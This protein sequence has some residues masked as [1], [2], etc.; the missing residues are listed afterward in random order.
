MR[1]AD[2]DV[3][4]HRLRQARA[5]AFPPGEFVGQESFVSAGEVLMLGR[6]AGIAPGVRVLDL[7]CGEGGPGLHLAREL[8]C[9]HLGVDASARS[10]AHARARADGEGVT[11]RFEVARVPP[12]PA[13][14][15]DV[16]LL[17]E[18]LLA[19]P[20][21]RAL[22]AEV[23]AALVPGG[24]FAFTLEEGRPLTPTEAGSMP[25][26]GTVWLTPL[27]RLRADLNRAGLRVRWCT[28]TSRAHRVTVDAL[29]DAYA[30]AAPDLRAAG[31]GP[32]VDDL[33][34]SH[35]LWSRWLRE[36]RVRKFAVVA[37]KVRPWVS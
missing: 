36:G 17:L 15:F 6:R 16:V 5:A 3:V 34:A 35:R 24:R 21:K 29:V 25:G 23:T 2:R 27:P 12:V 14:P 8:G 28:E 19:F 32:A 31:A 10:V 7:C 20:D 30:A 18:T 33:V 26:S 4:A 9:D 1:V 13:G 11:A 37:E 22:L